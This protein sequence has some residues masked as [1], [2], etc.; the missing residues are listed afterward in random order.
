MKRARAIRALFILSVALYPFIVYFG[1]QV[2]PPSFFGLVLVV[3]LAMRYGVLQPE[4]RPVLLPILLVFMT[5]AILTAVLQSTRMLLY[6][7]VLVNL[8]LCSVFVISLRRNDPLLLRIV[9]ARGMPVS[10]HGPRYLARLTGVWAGFF[11]ANG[12]LSLWT[13]TLSLATWTLY[14]GL[15][16]YFL[17]GVMVTAEWLFRGHYKRR[18]GVETS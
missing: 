7:P 18:M 14:N 9:R 6:Y 8:C 12:L 16:S 10:K 11:A 3:L 17:I 5:Y 13:T 2:L 4:E 15:I 1:I